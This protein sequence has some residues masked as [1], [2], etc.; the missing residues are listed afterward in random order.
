MLGIGTIC[1]PT[2][3][4]LNQQQLEKYQKYVSINAE[5][6]EKS[7]ELLFDKIKEIVNKTCI[8]ETL[9]NIDIAGKFIFGDRE[10]N[11]DRLISTI[12]IIDLVDLDSS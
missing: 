8:D 4:S 2:G 9:L 6:P 12:N 3:K 5:G 7:Y 1:L 11:F 10:L